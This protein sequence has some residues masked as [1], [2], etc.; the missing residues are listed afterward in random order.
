MDKTNKQQIE[1]IVEEV[2]KVY[3]NCGEQPCLLCKNL[4]ELKTICDRIL[5]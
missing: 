5:S 4:S 1:D 2:K 3:C